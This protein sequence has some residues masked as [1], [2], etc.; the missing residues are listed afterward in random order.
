MAISSFVWLGILV[1]ALALVLFSVQLVSGDA[2]LERGPG[3]LG[4]FFLVGLR[5]AIGWHFLIEAGEKLHDPAWTSEGYLRESTGPLAPYFRDLA[6]DSLV[7]QLT[8][9]DGAIAPELKDRW[10]AYVTAL[11]RYYDLT[12]AQVV[13]ADVEMGATVVKAEK[14]LTTRPRKTR[15]ITADDDGPPVYKNLTMPER[16]AIFEGLRDEIGRIE[17]R[18]LPYYGADAQKHWKKAKAD[19]AKWRAALQK[20]LGLVDKLFKSNVRAALLKIA[21]S[22]LP[23]APTDFQ[24]KLKEQLKKAADKRTEDSKKKPSPPDADWDAVAAAAAKADED[25]LWIYRKVFAE[26]KDTGQ[27]DKLNEPTR[28]LYDQIIDIKKP[29]ATS[30]DL[31]PFPVARPFSDWRLLDWSDALVK[32]GLLVVGLCLLLGFFTRI[33]CV[34][35]AVYLL[36]FY[37]AMPALP[38][39]P[40]PPRAEGHYL[41]INKNIIEMLALLALATLRTGRWAGI[42]GFLAWVWGRRRE[43]EAAPAPG[44]VA[45]SD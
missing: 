5:L 30:Y 29:P 33:A 35:G 16:L 7:E 38:G 17:K 43:N 18:E 34:L 6:G 23:T 27:W 25:N 19:A 45:H 11:S 42:D 3:A 20:D 31:L 40:D 36:L 12:P 24:A 2:R 10:Q 28:R 44:A 26:V 37:L 22:D 9:S 39:W 21:A 8:V 4:R 13:A 14:W 41:F 1:A 32:W 15:L